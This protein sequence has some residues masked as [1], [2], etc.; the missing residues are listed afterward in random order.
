M[1]G[2]CDNKVYDADGAITTLKKP[3]K[4]TCALVSDMVSSCLSSDLGLTAEYTT[5]FV[6]L[7]AAA[8]VLDGTGSTN[9]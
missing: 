1:C 3:Q 9:V 2:L 8:G 6:S 7:R 5:L 4:L